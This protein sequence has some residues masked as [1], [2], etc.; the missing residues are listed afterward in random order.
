MFPTINNWF[1]AWYLCPPKNRYGGPLP[2][3]Q[4]KDHSVH[5]SQWYVVN[6][7]SISPSL[8]ATLQSST[9]LH[10]SLHTSPHFNVVLPPWP[11]FFPRT[12]FSLACLLITN[13]AENISLNERWRKR[14]KKK[15]ISFVIN[16]A[17]SVS[18]QFRFVR[19]NYR[20]HKLQLN[21]TKKM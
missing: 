7:I 21:K 17:E 15:T 14:R 5:M 2:P 1:K 19:V 12:P 8:L 16:R 3:F 4:L 6:S 9:D 18:G 20:I 11:P 10:R 13:Q